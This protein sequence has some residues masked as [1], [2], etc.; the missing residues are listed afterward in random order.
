MRAARWVSGLDQEGCKGARRHDATHVRARRKLTT[1][2][3]R[4]V[5]VHGRY[6]LMLQMYGEKAEE[7]EELKMDLEDV[8]GELKRQMQMFLVQIEDLKGKN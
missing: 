8:K 6:Q 7:A 2:K 3:M 4:V 1:G 5:A